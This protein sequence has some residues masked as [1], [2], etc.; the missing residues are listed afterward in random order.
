MVG[1]KKIEPPC[2]SRLSCRCVYLSLSYHVYLFLSPPLL[3]VFLSFSL[4]HHVSFSLSPH[5][6]L[7]YYLSLSQILSVYL[8]FSL[9]HHIS[10][11][12]HSC[13]CIYLS[14][15]LSLS[16]SISPTSVSPALMS[17]L[18]SFSL[19]HSCLCFYL[20]FCHPVFLSLPHSCL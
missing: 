4:S 19:T 7:C 17:E 12:L 1:E 13:L 10:L 18:L 3:S 11:S 2:L 15:F 16:L 6:C 14:L 8:S 5:S 20:S 9:S